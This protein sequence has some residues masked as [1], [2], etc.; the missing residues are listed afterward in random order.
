MTCSVPQ[1]DEHVLDALA[2]WQ[3]ELASCQTMSPSRE[4]CD[5][6]AKILICWIL[7]KWIYSNRT[8]GS[9]LL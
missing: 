3:L 6:T 7:P 2:S 4:I 5:E 1:E 9:D 8:S